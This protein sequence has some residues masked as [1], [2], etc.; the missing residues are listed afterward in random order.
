[1]ALLL[2]RI[3]RF[4]YRR[5]WL[6][7]VGWIVAIAAILGVGLGL[8]GQLQESF[9]I[10]GTESQEAI[11]HLAAV[12]PQTAGASAK[13][14][15]EAP[16]GASV[17]DAPY[18]D[19]I[20]AMET[21]LE[22]VDGVASVLGPFDEYA[23]DQVSADGRTAYIQVQFD[24]QV[25]DVTDAS[26]ADV[27]ATGD[28]ASDAGMDVAFGGEV[29]QE[30]S[31]GLS[32]TEVFGVVFAGVVLLITFGSLLSAGMP[33]L[34][35][36]VGVA[37]AFG[38]I[39]LV[40][41]FTTVSSTAPMLAVMIGL[42]VGIDYALFILS[43]HRTGLA[44]GQD[45][46]E[47]AAESVATAGG[48]VVF[49]G[50]TVI[51]ALLGLLVV[52]I[53]F[54]SVM[55]VGAA[56]AVLVAVL[57]ATTL[58]PAIMGLAGTK[59]AP[60]PG[61]R[62]H[63]RANAD[64]EGGKRTMGRRWVDLVLKAPAV[65]VVLVAGVLGTA[66]IPAASLDLNLPSGATAEHG[67]QERKAYDMIAEG[68]GPGYN[69]PLV[70]TVDITQTTDIFTDLD[71]IRDR[72]AALD[73]VAY[74]G[75][76]LPNE[77]VDTAIIQVIPETAPND[78]ETKRIV[79]E[80][81]ELEPSITEDLG[82][83][84]AVT[85][86]TAVSIDISNRLND[87]LL[88]FALIVVGLSI[89]LL[90]IVFRS[91]FVPVKAAVGFLLSAFGAIGATV[92]VFQWGW[93]ADLLHIEPGPILSFLPIL[94]MAVLFGL[95]MDYE[96]FLVS[97]MREEY[98]KTKEPRRAITH[99]F[100]HAARVVTAAA[101]I[102]FFVF[103]AFVP[104]GSGVIK[105]IAF[106]LAIGVAFDAFLVR[107]TLVPAAMALAGKAAW[108]LPKWL[109][110]ILPSVDIE[111]EG[112]REHLDQ[113]AWASRSEA[114][115]RA[116]G[117]VF[118]LAERPIGPSTSMCPRARSSS[119][120]APPSI[121]ASSPR[122]SR[123]ASTP[124]RDGSRCSANPCR[125]RPG[126]CSAASPSPRRPPTPARARPS[127]KCSPHASTRRGPGTGSPRPAAESTCGSSGSTRHST[128]QAP[129][130]PASTAKPRSARSAPATAP[131]SHSPPRSPKAPTPSSSTSTTRP[132]PSR[133]P[134]GPPLRGSSPPAR[135]SWSASDT[136]TTPPR[137]RREASEPSPSAPHSRRPS[138]EPQA[139]TPVLAGH[140]RGAAPH[141]LRG[142]HRRRH[143]RAARRR[144][145]RRGRPRRRRPTTRDDPR[146][147]RQQRRDGHDD[148]RRRRRAA[149]ARGPPA[150]DRADRPEHGGLLVDDLERRRGR[151]GPRARR[152]L[153]GAHDPV[154]LLFVDRVDLGE[155]PQKADLSIRTDDAHGFLAGAVAQSVGQAMTATFGQQLTAQYLEGFYANLA[156]MG[157]SL[158]QAAD[159]ATQLSSGAGSLATGLGDLSSGVSQ[160]ATGAS[161]AAAGAWAY[162]D[163]VRQYTAGVDGIASGLGGLSTGAAG[164]DQ[165]SDNWDAYTG[166]IAQGVAT[167]DG[168]LG[169]ASDTL[170]QI[171][172]DNPD[173]LTQYPELGGVSATIEGVR[174]QL[175]DMA[176]GGQ[177]LAAASRGAIDG[178][179]GG[180]ADLAGGAAQLSAGS[181]GLRD[182]ATSLASGVDGLATGLGQLS[183]GASS[184][185][186]GATDLAGGATQLADGLTQGA[187]DASALS[188]IDAATT[189][190]VVSQPVTVDTARNHEISG[191]G[192]VIGMLFAP[193]GLWV[194]A[195]ALFLVLR[196]FP[197]DALRS[198]TSTGGLVGRALWR[199]GLIALAQAAAVVALLHTALG[200]SWTLLPQ[201]L[202]FSALLALVFT[203]LHGFLQTALGRAGTL[204]SLVLVALQ[205]AST[206]GLYPVEVLSGPF[207]AISR[208][209]PLTWAV[210]GMQGI[211]AG[212]SSGQVAGAAG[213]LALFGIGAVVATAAVVARRRG[214]R[215]TGFAAAAIG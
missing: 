113:A 132:R 35:A 1:M 112:L 180:I 77:T 150:R 87:A 47:S 149:R 158:G 143:P 199:T 14:V 126:A 53:P 106:A 71:D 55:G 101:L 31:F 187:K 73:G 82:T 147:R 215:S 83:P 98:V 171:L 186:S 136:A 57:A 128:S 97:G 74:V 177:Q 44:R 15:V 203:A 188:D 108:W 174:T 214:I 116:D 69:G 114:A 91:V 162:A 127:A 164:L 110:R 89:V 40:A 2:H 76:G 24:G 119:S 191:S 157:G 38:G 115:I 3:G 117:A 27:V 190:D 30:T 43:R 184:A 70:V 23:G 200:V 176:S 209:L 21:Q 60:K 80:I 81:R 135:P 65:A 107:M 194:G 62:A 129:A 32:I 93:F 59:L 20:T 5:A 19:A 125:R 130:P 12:F 148:G 39:S 166:G 192:E 137:S 182:G 94:L 155:D 17:E 139:P 178:I 146:D 196:P 173:L 161:D 51:I 88:P 84:I 165:I 206:G 183:A 75:E 8:G 124:S 121:A 85:G 198:T 13:A 34:T 145:P 49:A 142:A 185:A 181:A 213:V 159:G 141:P 6:V 179:Q 204:V 48:A 156:G 122:P 11:D 33:L 105:G 197:R 138:D 86:Y 104:E 58:L 9:A 67:T 208:L 201:T 170:A 99:G 95:A 4:A 151:A 29:F 90:L 25:S 10:P 205:L 172:A 52:G 18:R 133:P 61:S 169:P 207:Q 210:E 36:L 78:P 120:K 102:M 212:A 16:D 64:D 96:V 109:A 168:Y 22:G 66:A 41:A 103:F 154:G 79:E 68:F 92:A 153:R 175:G 28:L 202:A 167:V 195:L 152:R 26:I 193:I 42:A 56:F 45:P 37:V 54:L 134:S 118:G 189:A 163:G 111:G 160:A 63:R 211:V 140:D 50:L 72:L 7:L 100:Q 123:A 144:G 131:S 46:E